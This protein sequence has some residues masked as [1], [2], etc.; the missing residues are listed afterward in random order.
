MSGKPIV[1]VSANPPLSPVLGE[2]LTVVGRRRR[3]AHRLRKLCIIKLIWIACTAVVYGGAIMIRGAKMPT[4]RA[5]ETEKAGHRLSITLNDAQYAE[6]AAIARKNRVS[7]AWVV[8]E[9][10]EGLISED[11]PLVKLRSNAS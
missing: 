5:I 11:R 10:V 8:R 9:A 6:I 7:I 4:T 3:R 1:T 2:K